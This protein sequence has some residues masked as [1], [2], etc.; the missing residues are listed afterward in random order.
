[1]YNIFGERAERGSIRAM[2]K[3]VGSSSWNRSPLV[4]LM[5][6][7]IVAT[8]FSAVAENRFY[9]IRFSPADPGILQPSQISNIQISEGSITGEISFT[10]LSDSHFLAISKQEFL[11]GKLEPKPGDLL[12]AV[13]SQLGLIGPGATVVFKATF[14]DPDQRVTIDHAFDTKSAL[15]TLADPFV[16]LFGPKLKDMSPDKLVIIIE[17]LR[18]VQ[19]FLDAS[20]N[21][22]A[23]TQSDSF[24]ERLYQSY[25][26]TANLTSAVTDLIG[27]GKF[28]DILGNLGIHTTK[29]SVESFLDATKIASLLFFDAQ[30]L[31][32]AG[33][34]IFDRDTVSIEPLA[35]T[36]S[37][38]TFSTAGELPSQDASISICT[39]D[40]VVG[41][42]VLLRKGTEIRQGNGT[43]YAIH[44]VVPVDNWPVDVI[45]GPRCVDGSDW[46]DISRANIDGGG[47]GWGNRS[48]AAL[49]VGTSAPSSGT[50]SGP[51]PPQ[52]TPSFVGQT[53][54]WNGNSFR[55]DNG[56]TWIFQ[57]SDAERA[58]A[59]SEQKARELA[60][61]E[62]MAQGSGVYLQKANLLE[63]FNDINKNASDFGLA[64][65]EYVI[66]RG[67]YKATLYS[68]YRGEGDVIGVYFGEG[69]YRLPATRVG[70]VRAEVILPPEPE[71][72]PEIPVPG[73]EPE[74]DPGPEPSVPSAPPPSTPS[75]KIVFT[76][77]RDGNLAVYS[78]D[79]DGS[80]QI[81]LTRGVADDYSPS[82]SLDGTKIAFTSNRDGNYR[83]Y[84]MNADGTGQVALTGSGSHNREAAWS[85]DGT[86]IAFNSA[87]DGNDEIY[88]MNADGS[89]PVRLTF[90][91]DIVDN[92][93]SWSPDGTKIAF[94]SARDGNDEIYS[95][96]SNGTGQTRLTNTPFSESKAAWSPDGSKIVFTSR[97]DG[98]NEIYSM[99]ADGSN[100]TRL[101]DSSASLWPSWIANG[102]IIFVTNRDGN[103]EIYSMDTNGANQTN[104]T[105]NSFADMRPN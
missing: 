41:S 61:A 1:M 38:S 16:E 84:V 94:S 57:G 103:D 68:W 35:A 105:N 36:G 63:L 29:E 46:G 7:G 89:N 34:L 74:S 69:T 53:V 81:N 45:D 56:T 9:G 28:V 97:R 96:N 4:L 18:N 93:P 99:N 43:S 6:V 19:G 70:S 37:D 27:T 64:D 87:R 15:L 85:P 20:N 77:D 51:E 17:K 62:A 60:E 82:Q 2:Q 104:L 12:S 14:T 102:A 24:E 31:F 76:S 23:I 72:L 30:V 67:P 26:L 73:P 50:Y 48:Q 54:S 39:G 5:I 21:V 92:L 52:Y 91:Y 32:T 80:N 98:H 33:V 79:V 90:N 3:R 71:P 83:V 101:T 40:W 49:V 13:Y 59:E 22:L 42:R 55:S 44:T 86:K 25:Q 10:N 78:M 75:Q 66:I 88:V 47:T 65:A 11:G 58:Q 95:M 100:Q 8:P